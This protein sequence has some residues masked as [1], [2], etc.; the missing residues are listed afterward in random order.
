MHICIST[1]DYTVKPVLS[2]HPKQKTN[3]RLMQ[4]ES[5]VECSKGG[6]L[7]SFRP[8]SLVYEIQ[9]GPKLG[10]KNTP[11]SRKDENGLKLKLIITSFN[12]RL[13]TLRKCVAP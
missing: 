10:E 4:D 1:A 7:Q 8:Y 11:I 9:K 12:I 3:H 13:L 6:I 2:G 5:I